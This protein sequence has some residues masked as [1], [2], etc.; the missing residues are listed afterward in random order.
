M[1]HVVAIVEKSRVWT[2]TTCINNQLH[3]WQKPITLCP[4]VTNA[5]YTWSLLT[6]QTSADV[7]AASEDFGVGRHN[8][9][10]N[11]GGVW[12]WMFVLSVLLQVH[13]RH[14]AFW[15]L[16]ALVTRFHQVNLWLC[17]SVQ[18]RLRHALVVAQS[19][20]VLTD[21][22]ISTAAAA[23]L[24]ASIHQHYLTNKQPRHLCF[25]INNLSSDSHATTSTIPFQV[26]FASKRSAYTTKNHNTVQNILFNTLMDHSSTDFYYFAAD[27]QTVSVI[28][29]PA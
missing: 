1:S 5:Q 22:C 11:D 20:H 15:A 18:V 7:S 26:Q 25:V 24:T 8:W 16:D 14:E 12:S 3:H 29:Y 9:Y 13:R 23:T 28:N 19:T 6:Q 2:Q 27:S 17:V 4:S 21:S 10:M